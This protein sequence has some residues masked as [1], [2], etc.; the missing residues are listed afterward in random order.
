MNL[1]KCKRISFLYDQFNYSSSPLPLAGE[2]SGVRAYYVS[3][4]LFMNRPIKTERARDF[5]KK[6]TES[7]TILWLELRNRAFMDL[8]FRRQYVIDGLF[9]IFI[10]RS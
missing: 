10:A 2:G 1:Y 6:L 8:K 4:L 7:E 3:R 9:W 5:R